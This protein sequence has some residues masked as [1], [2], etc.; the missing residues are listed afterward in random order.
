MRTG[1][2]Y[3]PQYNGNISGQTWRD[4]YNNER[5]AYRYGYDALS[6][7]TS[8]TYGVLS[9]TTLT[10]TNRYNE[11]LTYDLNGNTKSM[12][13]NGYPAYLPPS[14]KKVCCTAEVRGTA[15]VVLTC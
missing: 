8:S 12:L 11:N 2:A 1:L 14:Q 15:L 7:L 4:T 5:A 3:T 9:G 6:R 13:R 10:Q